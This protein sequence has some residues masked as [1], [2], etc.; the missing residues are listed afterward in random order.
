MCELAMPGAHN[1]GAREVQ[2]IPPAV[3]SGYIGGF[4]AGMSFVNA[5]AKP[6]A[7]PA[8]VCQSLTVG[9]LLRAGIRVL[10][11]RLGLHDGQVYICHA[12]VCGISLEEAL[13]EAA[14]FLRSRE[15]EVVAILIKKDWEHRYFDESLENWA[16]V[17]DCLLRVLGDLVLTDEAG[18]ALPIEE[19]CRR[20]Q[21]AVVL[22]EAPPGVEL[23]AALPMN[24]ATLDK[25]WKASTQTV[26]D[27][28]GVLAEWR[29][30]NRMLPQPGL[31]KFLE[32]AVPGGPRKTAPGGN[33]AFRRFLQ[34]GP[35]SIGAML[36]DPD[37]DTIRAIV[38]KNWE[39]C[40]S[41]SEA[42]FPASGYVF[43]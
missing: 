3:L 1:S 33:A 37:E 28:L 6:F 13:Q 39:D 10:D 25:S 32:V 2:C 17:Q 7:T 43:S 42:L 38:L 14:S 22:V 18:M 19:L 26:D 23:F 31:L 34:G 27:M 16:M 29:T 21:R 24:G 8:A 30:T 41:G 9:E 20:G 36:D 4:L 40:G 11:F 12:V 5:I 35:L 15:S